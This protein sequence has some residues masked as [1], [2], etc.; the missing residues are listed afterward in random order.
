M[1]G[2]QLELTFGITFDC[3]DARVQ[4][5]FWA[6]ALGYVEAPP[7]E[8]WSTWEAF[9]TDHGVPVEE[10]ADGAA[11]CP[12]S[13]QGPTIGFLRVPEPKT[14]KNRVHLDLKV[15]GGRHVDQAL[16]DARIRAKQSELS[17]AGATT[18]REVWVEDRLDHLLMLDPEGNEFCI[19]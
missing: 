9:L 14:V 13:G 12:A 1:V 5:R 2:E 7:P 6:L 19:V 17:N 10:W 8:G 11:L 16:R 18:Q 15:S 3:A 4:A